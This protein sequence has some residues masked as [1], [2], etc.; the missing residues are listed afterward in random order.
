VRATWQSPKNAAADH[1]SGDLLNLD[2]VLGVHLNEAIEIGAAGNVVQQIG[3]DRGTGTEL[4][5]FMTQ[6]ISI[7]PAGIYSAAVGH[8][9]LILGV[10]WEHD[11]DAHNTFEGDVVTAQ[12]T[13]VL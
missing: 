11:V 8:T 5:P 1:Q 7:G 2:W 9:P 4:E 10:K 3:A 13:V 12:A 6:S